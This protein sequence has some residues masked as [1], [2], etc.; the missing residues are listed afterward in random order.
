[1]TDAAR[2]CTENVMGR[3]K[4][5]GSFLPDSHPGGAGRISGQLQHFLH[6]DKAVGKG[7]SDSQPQ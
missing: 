2:I 1:M 7:F 6:P 4:K 5:M 3:R